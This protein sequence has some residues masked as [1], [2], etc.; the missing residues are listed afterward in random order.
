MERIPYANLVGSIMYAMVCT[1]P[2]LS[3]SVSIVS[4]FMVD[5]CKEHWHALKCALRYI[6]GTIGKGLVFGSSKGVWSNEGVI[7]GFVDSDFA[8]CLD[9]RK[10]LTGY[11]LTT[12]GTTITWRASLQK[13][14][15][16]SSTEA[17]YMALT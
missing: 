11:V 13:V 12:F 7:T 5:P 16:L 8:G 4:R 6:K 3:Y 1:R 17:E 2:D 15:A 14:V 10:S 9:S